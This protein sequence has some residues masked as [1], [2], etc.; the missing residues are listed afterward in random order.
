MKVCMVSG[1]FPNMK[2][3]VGDYTYRL[4]CELKKLGIELDV[5]T[6]QNP[7]VIKDK[8]LKVDPIIEK[9]SFSNLPLLLKSI[10]TKKPDLVHLQYPTQAYKNRIAINFFPFIFGLTAS[11]IPLVVT[12]HDAKTANPLN[13]LRL[14]P[15]LFSAKEIILT[16]EEERQYLLK[17][18]PGLLSRLKVIHVGSNIKAH[19]FSRSQ[20][21]QIRSGLGLKEK[22]ILLAHFGYILKKKGLEV[23]FYALRRLLDEGYRIKL[24][25]IS[26]FNPQGDSYHARLKKLIARLGLEKIVIRTGYCDQKTVSGY[27]SSS[28]ICVQIYQDGVSFRRT[29]FMTP[30]GH[31]LPI[32]TTRPKNLPSPCAQGLG[33]PQGLKERYNIIG[34]SVGDVEGLANAIKELIASGE[35]RQKIGENAKIFSQ[36]FSWRDIAQEHINLYDR[37]V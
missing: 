6:S 21:E 32:I 18:F 22:E 28:D 11:G 5:I 25:L 4:S 1:T 27:L 7:Q 16:A 3:G 36:Q 8:G 29:S 2:C 35:L 24:A 37:L 14:L 33:L 30:L 31:G 15:F 9:W 12:I 17:R 20:Q 26:E 23:M 19:L 34:V 13:K 10:K